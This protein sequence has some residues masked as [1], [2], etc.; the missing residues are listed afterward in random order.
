MEDCEGW[1]LSSCH[2]SLGGSIPR[3]LP[4][5]HFP[6]FW[7]DNIKHRVH[8]AYPKALV[9]E[10]VHRLLDYGVLISS[11]Q[12]DVIV[13]VVNSALID[14]KVAMMLLPLTTIIYRVS[15]VAMETYWRVV[16]LPWKDIYSLPPSLPPSLPRR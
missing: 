11:D 13:K 2:S 1:W 5:F 14:E 8:L 15:V 3:Q 7:P 4:A 9:S 16:L 10:L 12:F 6:L